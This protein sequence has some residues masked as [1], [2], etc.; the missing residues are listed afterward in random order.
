MPSLSSEM[1]RVGRTLIKI[2]SSGS[3]RGR[4][5][6]RVHGVDDV[7][8]RSLAKPFTIVC[9]KYEYHLGYPRETRQ[10]GC[11]TSS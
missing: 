4:T 1:G 7:G 10:C 8:T 11:C 6:C 3:C 5:I 2:L 9:R